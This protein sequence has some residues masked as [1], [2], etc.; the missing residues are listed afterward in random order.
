MHDMIFEGLRVDD[1]VAEQVRVIGHVAAEE[2]KEAFDKKLKDS[3]KQCQ[4]IEK[5]I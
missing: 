1:D 4:Q 2:A 3:E 5:T